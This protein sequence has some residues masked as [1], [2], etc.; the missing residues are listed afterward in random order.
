MTKEKRILG[1]KGILIWEVM[2]NKASKASWM[3]VKSIGKV[4]CIFMVKAI[5]HS[6]SRSIYLTPGKKLP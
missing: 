1:S 6:T 2:R 4:K 3:S 5:I